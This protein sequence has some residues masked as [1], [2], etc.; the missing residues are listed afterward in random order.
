MDRMPI[1][2]RRT[3]GTAIGDTGNRKARS[4]APGFLLAATDWLRESR[5]KVRPRTAGQDQNDFPSDPLRAFSS[6]VT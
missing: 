4:I 2:A 3:I 5:H 1:T 6:V